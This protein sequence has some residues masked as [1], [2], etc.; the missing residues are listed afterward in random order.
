MAY[1]HHMSMDAALFRGR[2][3]RVGWGPNWTMVHAGGPLVAVEDTTDTQ[4]Q[5]KDA[6]FSILPPTK[7][8]IETTPYQVLLHRT[9]LSQTTSVL[10]HLYYYD[11]LYYLR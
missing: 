7:R 5:G 2:C 9:P 3:C 1:K 10:Y 4:P 8:G 11:N 6:R